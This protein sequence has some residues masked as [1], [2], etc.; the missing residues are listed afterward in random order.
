MSDWKLDVSARLRWIEGCMEAGVTS[1]DLADIYGDYEVEALFGESLARSSSLRQRMQLVSK[2]GIKLIS[3]ARPSHAIKSYDTSRAHIVSSVERSLTALRT[4]RLDLL[5]IHRPD[6]LMNPDEV[7]ETFAAL[8]SAGKVLHFGVSTHSP[9]QLALL[10]HRARLCTNQVEFSPL[11]LGALADGTLDQCLDLG[12]R[13][14][15]WSPLGG[16]RIFGGSD[17]RAQRVRAA[18]TTLAEGHGTSTATIAYAWIMRHPSSPLPITGSQ[19]LDG[20]REAVAALGVSLS[21]EEWY[22]VWEAG[23]GH[24]VA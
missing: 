21:A 3:A 7:A 6:A 9:S 10:H 19:R 15:I 5:L 14:M 18:L 22:R 4:D 20:V 1:F 24:E 11:E 13:P 17:A 12:L 8:R 16:G 2:C 23:A